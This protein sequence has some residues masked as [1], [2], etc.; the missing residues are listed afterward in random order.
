MR[1]RI[2]AIVIAVLMVFPISASAKDFCDGNIKIDVPDGWSYEVHDSNLDVGGPFKMSYVWA[3][4][5]FKGDQS[6]EIFYLSDYGDESFDVAPLDVIS[7]VCEHDTLK[8]EEKYSLKADD[9]TLLEKC[10]MIADGNPDP[11]YRYMENTETGNI[12]FVAGSLEGL[13]GTSE[14]ELAEIE[15]CIKSFEDKGYAAHVYEQYK[16][17]NISIFFTKHFNSGWFITILIILGIF[18]IF[19]V[20]LSITRRSSRKE[21][22]KNDVFNDDPLNRR[23]GSRKKIENGV[24]N[25]SLEEFYEA[26]YI[27]HDEY[28]ELVKRYREDENRS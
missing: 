11:I 4:S 13:D 20:G 21:K 5:I 9:G 16:P 18:L 2:L 10:D 23:Y 17:T 14:R 19:K 1:R 25:G 15:K 8:T 12:V 28:L 26:G 3:L 24:F 7:N 27:S 6:I 22:E